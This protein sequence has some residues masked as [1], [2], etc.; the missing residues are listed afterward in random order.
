MDPSQLRLAIA[1]RQ[2]AQSRRAAEFSADECLFGIQ[3]ECNRSKHQRKIKVCGRRSGKTY[4]DAVDLIL[5]ALEPPIVP[6]LYVTLTRGNAKEIIWPDLVRLN[7]EYSL[8]FKVKEA[9]LEMISPIGV[10][11]QL[12]GAHTAAEIEKYRG[13]KFKKA[14]IDEAGSFPDRV[15]RPLIQDVIGPALMDYQGDLTLTGTPP[16]L[17][18]GFFYERWQARLKEAAQRGCKPEELGLFHWTVRENERFPA[19]LRGMSIEEILADIRKEFGWDESNPSYRREYLGE[20]IEDLEALLFEYQDQRNHYDELPPGRWHYVVALDLGHDD[21]SALAVLGWPDG[22]RR[23]YLVDEWRDN[24]VDVTDCAEKLR[25]FS[26][27]YKP[28]GMVIDQGGLGKMIAV[29]IRRRHSLPVKPADK[30]QKPAHI[31]LLNTALRK[32][33]LVA[34]RDSF[35]A[36]ECGLVRKDPE[37]LVE[38]K[39]QELPAK[40]GGYHGNMTDA[41]LYGWRECNAFW[42]QEPPERPVGYQEPSDHIKQVI[43][44]QRREQYRDP[45]AVAFGFDD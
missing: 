27:R 22:H 40:K 11:I 15:I 39:L 20:D 36:E 9:A 33:E 4:E 23:V 37:A 12:R 45:E 18:R 2:H 24:K 7:T 41:V 17:R 10:P 29:E 6:E 26:D 19:R 1:L 44:E 16:P 5:G 43:V 30:A 28:Q 31:K 25:E 13:K 8:G 3:R 14:K 32:R 38:G 42:E 35:F 34:R 21:N